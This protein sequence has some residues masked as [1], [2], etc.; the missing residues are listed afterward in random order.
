MALMFLGLLAV[1]LLFCGKVTVT[2]IIYSGVCSYV[3]E[4]YIKHAGVWSSL[5]VYLSISVGLC[6]LCAIVC[7]IADTEDKV[8]FRREVWF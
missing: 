2:D 1:F 4:R 5:L 6:I 7:A 8:L 3:S